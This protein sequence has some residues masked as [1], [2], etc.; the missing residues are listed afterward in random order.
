ML[1]EEVVKLVRAALSTKF[2]NA[3]IVTYDEQSS[4]F[5]TVIDDELTFDV[6]VHWSEDSSLN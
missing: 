1:Q 6:E 4:P 2:P 5:I 3:E